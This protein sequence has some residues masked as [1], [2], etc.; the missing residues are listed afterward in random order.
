MPKT[1]LTA[2]EQAYYARHISLAE[3]GKAGQEKLKASSAVLVGAGGL[4][5]PLALYLAA[6]GVGRIG[7]LDFDVV[8]E[9]NLQR[10]IIHDTAGIGTPKLQS[11]KK[12]LLA[13]NP[14]ITVETHEI[15]LSSANA[16]EL[17][18]QY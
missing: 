6:A 2:A 5:S 4:G 7:I 11:A 3:I 1:Q 10:Q 8:D 17:F 9:S 14:Y 13:L 15:K 16:V 12:R 18:K